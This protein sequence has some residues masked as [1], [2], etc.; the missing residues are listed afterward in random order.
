MSERIYEISIWEDKKI[1][2]PNN[3]GKYIYREQK[4][5]VIGANDLPTVCKAVEPQ[6]VSN[7]N[8]TNVF[9]FK[10]YYTYVDNTTGETFDNPFINLLVNE[11]RIKVYWPSSDSQKEWYDLVIKKCEK[12]SSGKSITY[13]CT[14]LFINELSKTGF[15]LEFDTSLENNQGTVIELGTRVVDGTDWHVIGSDG[16]IQQVQADN[17]IISTGSPISEVTF[18]DFVKQEQ[19]EAVYVQTGVTLSGAVN[20]NDGTSLSLSNATILIFYSCV[21]DIEDLGEDITRKIQFLY[22]SSGYETDLNTITVN[23]AECYSFEGTWHLIK[24]NGVYKRQFRNGDTVYFHIEEGREVSSTYRGRRLV[25]EQKTVY[26]SLT[27]KY[28]QIFTDTDNKTVYRYVGTDYSDATTVTN[29]V[30]NSSNFNGIEGWINPYV[31]TQLYP[32]PKETTDFSSYNGTTYL[33][34]NNGGA[35]GWIYNIGLQSYS[36]FLSDGIQK[37]DVYRFRIKAYNDNNGVPGSQILTNNNLQVRIYNYQESGGTISPATSPTNYASVTYVSD[38]EWLI[39]DLTITKSATRSELYNDKIGL[40]IR[41]NVSDNPVIWIKEVQ[42][43]KKITNTAGELIE[44]DSILTEDVAAI[45]YYYYNKTDAISSGITD[46]EDINYIYKGKTDIQPAGL[47]PVMNNFIKIRSI[48]AKQSNRFN[49]LQSLAETFECWVKFTIIHDSTGAIQY[50][51]AGRPKK[52]ISFVNNIGIDNGLTFEYGIDLKTIKRTVD[53]DAIVTKTI[54][55]QNSNEYASNGFCTIARASENP[56]RDN[57]ILNFDYYLLTGL[58]D[59]SELTKDLYTA[60]V[61]Y[62]QETGF[63]VGAN[64]PVSP[65][66][67]KLNANQAYV[68]AKGKYASG[69]SYYLQK[70]YASTDT[71]IGYFYWLRKYN[72]EYDAITEALNSINKILLEQESTVNLNTDAITAATEQV[73]VLTEEILAKAATTDLKNIQKYLQKSSLVTGNAMIDSLLVSYWHQKKLITTY[74]NANTKLNSSNVSVKIAK[75]AYEARQA[76]I[77]SLKKLLHYDFFKKYGHFIQEGA[78]NSED[79]IDDTNYYFDALNVAIT[80]SIPKIS[81]SIDVLRLSALEEYKYKIFNVGDICYVR[82]NEFFNGIKQKVLISEISFDFDNPQN[83]K[84]TV[85]NYK[86][87]FEDLFQRITATTQSLQYASGDYSRAAAAITT[88]G[89]IQPEIL[90]NSFAINQQLVISAHNDV[91]YWDETGLTVRDSTDANRRTRITSGGLFITTDGGATWKNAVRGEGIATSYLTAG[92]IN[93]NSINLFDGNY[94]TFRWDATGIN[95]YNKQLVEGS[96][97]DYN[98]DLSS[99]VRFD[100]Y[101]IYGI[102]GENAYEPASEADIWNNA[103]F[104]LTWR[105]FFVK[106]KY[107]THYVEVSSE[108]DIQVVKNDIPVIKIGQ[109]DS[110]NNIYGIR[111]KNDSGI[112]TLETANNGTLWLQDQLNIGAISGAGY[113]A[114]IGH[115]PVVT[116]AANQIVYNSTNLDTRTASDNLIQRTLSVNNKFVIWEDGTMYAKDG[117]FEGTINATGGHIGNMTINAVEEATYKVKITSSNGQILKTD[118][119]TT[120]LEA[121]LYCGN[122]E[123]TENLTYQWYKNDVMLSEETN[124]TLVVEGEDIETVAQYTCVITKN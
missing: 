87:Q 59:A 22:S 78:W 63:T 29:L 50:D 91:V 96:S 8:G 46:K 19:E 23:N 57:F 38:G 26:D 113:E 99:F 5:A 103:K 51:S 15:D 74:T 84:I 104:G 53:S 112:I 20:D 124:S 101:G 27:D 47:T 52:Y 42:L 94:Q 62:T 3:A 39:Y 92:S 98:I 54:V 119:A 2:D 30:V 100:H 36:S 90:Q 58:L 32:L 10:M 18:S 106:N 79:Y 75:T 45:Y 33:K 114:S 7:I 70:D 37:G 24:D 13:T 12:D 28:C 120:T 86:S 6:M 60:T 31:T 109:L 85:Q 89:A 11:R 111:L 121:K 95:A 14:D 116:N 83:D 69:T 16:C 41:E 64:I 97:T 72:I 56:T 105:G 88:E 68:K 123:V 21:P 93:V 55:K 4:I 107:G 35:S 48:T 110:V 43:Y 61:G 102:T 118:E 40:F 82:D 115:L 49:I 9:T 76:Q 44:P 34:I 122:T 25:D 81:Y 65:Q 73:A 77:L 67:Y 108:N 17:T 66:R 71:N 80:S 117:Y 1:A